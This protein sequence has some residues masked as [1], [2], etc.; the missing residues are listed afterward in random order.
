MTRLLALIGAALVAA[1]LL[2]PEE[3]AMA[4]TYARQIIDQLATGVAGYYG[5]MAR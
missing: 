5:G 3:V 4:R 1:L 2:F